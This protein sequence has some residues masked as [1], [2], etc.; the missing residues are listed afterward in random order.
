MIGFHFTKC[1]FMVMSIR[2]GWI[3]TVVL[4]FFIDFQC[5]TLVKSTQA[6]VLLVA[7]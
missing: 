6:K 2:A 4:L 3:G 7:V 1:K 5:C